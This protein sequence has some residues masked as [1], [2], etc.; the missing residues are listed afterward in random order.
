MHILLSP[1]FWLGAVAGAG[2]MLGWAVFWHGPAEY[3]AGSLETA[4][5]LDAAT[6]QALKELEDEADRAAFLYRQC[7]ELGRLY[8]LATGRCLEGPA[9]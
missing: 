7:V 3:R 1:N 9:D 4:A 2:I 8:D 5:R 6:S